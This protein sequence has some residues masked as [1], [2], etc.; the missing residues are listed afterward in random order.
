MDEDPDRGQLTVLLNEVRQ[1]NRQHEGQLFEM[2]YAQMRRLAQKQMGGERAGHTLQATALVNEAYLRI[3]GR[4]NI[5]W[6]DR[7]HF[8]AIAGREFR[9]ALVE[10]ARQHRA[11]KRGGSAPK[12]SLEDLGHA[13]PGAA[14]AFDADALAIDDALEQLHQLDPEAARVVELK[15]FSGLTDE[16]AAAEMEISFAKVRRHWTFA[17]A[18]LAAKL[19][20][21]A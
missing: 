12:V 7:N 4:D 3:F 9:R 2:I 5:P 1:G 14:A 18:W 8:L 10:H 11:D 19:G 13:E 16:E 21:A 20:P 15:F 17:R 6:Q